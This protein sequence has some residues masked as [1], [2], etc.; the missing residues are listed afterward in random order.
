LELFL[1]L[2]Q[3][4]MTLLLCIIKF[5]PSCWRRLNARYSSELAL[6]TLG[7]ARLGIERIAS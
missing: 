2:L 6:G 4:C 3:M 5:L 7:W 1:V